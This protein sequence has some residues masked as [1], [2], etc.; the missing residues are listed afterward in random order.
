FV[1]L[2]RP[3]SLHCF[4]LLFSTTPTTPEIYTL[5]LHDALPIL[6]EIDK[7]IESLKDERANLDGAIAAALARKKFAERFAAASPAGLGEK[8]SEE[9]TSELQSH[10]KL[11]CRLLLEKKKIEQPD[12]GRSLRGPEG[13]ERP[14]VGLQRLP[15][16]GPVGRKGQHDEH[17][18]RAQQVGL[19]CRETHA[20]R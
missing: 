2:I 3:L 11:V 19:R 5:S 18:R 15:Q 1:Y 9:H 16:V 7:R 17:A 8:R 4:T 10:L 14:Q 12:I 13:G 20:Q 6:P